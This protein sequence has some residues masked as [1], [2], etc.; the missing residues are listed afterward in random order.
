MD[1]IGGCFVVGQCVLRGMMDSFILCLR[2]LFVTCIT[3]IGGFF[4][5]YLD[6]LEVVEGVYFEQFY[7]C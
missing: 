7:G 4:M 3:D 5:A 2:L 6:C 1:Y